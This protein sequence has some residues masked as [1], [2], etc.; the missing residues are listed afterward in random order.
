[1]LAR[2]LY[3][4]GAVD[5]A[6]AR[7]AALPALLAGRAGAP[8]AAT[9]WESASAQEFLEQLGEELQRLVSGLTAQQLRSPAG[10]AAFELLDEVG[11]LR[12]AVG[13]GSN[14]NRELLAEAIL[15]K[16]QR[17]LGPLSRGDN[18]VA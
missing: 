9:A 12:A 5:E 1:M 18:M 6:R 4:D 10:R 7:R 15:S 14:P 17:Q 3:L 11:R 16:I 2:Q 8:L 13:A